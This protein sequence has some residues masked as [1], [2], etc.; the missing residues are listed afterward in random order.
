MTP[1]AA[2]TFEPTLFGD[3]GGPA[4]ANAAPRFV[5]VAID[6]AGGGGNR[7]YTYHLPARLAD[8]QPG[9]AVMV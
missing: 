1:D 2:A 8:V 4:A 6:A 9:E 7:T 5:E 3:D